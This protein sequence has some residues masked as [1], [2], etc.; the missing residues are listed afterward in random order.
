MYG[1]I[2]ADLIE[3]LEGNNKGKHLCKNTD[4]INLFA[5]PASQETNCQACQK[6]QQRDKDCVMYGHLPLLRKTHFV[7][8]KPAFFRREV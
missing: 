1:A 4:P 3:G 8:K 7:I 2:D 5:Y 6:R